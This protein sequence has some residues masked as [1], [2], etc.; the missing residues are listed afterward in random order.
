MR[1][2]FWS[3]NLS[4]IR[5]IGVSDYLRF[6]MVEDGLSDKEARG[7]FWIVDKDGLLHS[8]RGDLPTSKE[9]MPGLAMKLRTG[10]VIPW[11]GRL[12]RGDS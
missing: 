8:D 10:H 1:G 6:A 9:P 11:S 5:A 4:L 2:R 7:R 12:G 3:V